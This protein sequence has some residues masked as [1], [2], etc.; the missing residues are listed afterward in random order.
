[1]S[2]SSQTCHNSCVCVCIY[3]VKYSVTFSHMLT[4]TYIVSMKTSSYQKEYIL[5]NLN[6]LPLSQ[7]MNIKYPIRKQNPKQLNLPEFLC[8][9]LS[10]SWSNPNHIK[11][12]WSPLA[13][14]S[15]PHI[16]VYHWCL[17]MNICHH[18]RQQLMESW[19]D[20]D[21]VNAIYTHYINAS[22][23]TS[24]CSLS[25]HPGSHQSLGH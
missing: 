5:F 4:C 11:S 10:L 2:L 15:T 24:S 17:V 18:G 9:N 3:M 19:L 8:I 25:V 13:E 22:L 12:K 20:T 6:V 1:M 21:H 16:Y 7:P 14:F 23:F